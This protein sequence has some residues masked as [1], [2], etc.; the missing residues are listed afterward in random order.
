MHFSQ[1]RKEVCIMLRK[2]VVNSL[3]LLQPQISTDQFYGQHFAVAQGGEVPRWRKRVLGNCCKQAV[4]ASSIWQK[5][6]NPSCH[7]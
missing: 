6:V 2:I 4:T 1:R 3:I 5:I 7:L